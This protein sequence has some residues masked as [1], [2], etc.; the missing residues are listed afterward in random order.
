MGGWKHIMSIEFSQLQ[1]EQI[2]KEIDKAIVV[3]VLLENDFG[4]NKD[5]SSASAVCV[6]KDILHG[7]KDMITEI[8]K[9]DIKDKLD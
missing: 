2:H 6:I 7:V 5:I 4:T 1:I 8:S 3:A 9:D